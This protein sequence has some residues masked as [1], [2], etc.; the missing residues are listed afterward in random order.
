MLP[1]GRVVEG[2]NGMVQ[3]DLQIVEDILPSMGGEIV[4]EECDVGGVFNS[5]C[6]QGNVGCL[7]GG[8]ISRET[9]QDDQINEI[10]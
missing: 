5:Q 4:E 9:L 6:M 8:V 7:A 10:M 3:E 1:R 2:S